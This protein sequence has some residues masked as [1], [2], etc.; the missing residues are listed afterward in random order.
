[1]ALGV[2]N[3]NCNLTCIVTAIKYS[4]EENILGVTI[5]NKLTLEIEFKWDPHVSE[6]F[7]QTKIFPSLVRKNTIICLFGV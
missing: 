6:N 3:Y 4:N 1:M 2:P 5:D 7:C